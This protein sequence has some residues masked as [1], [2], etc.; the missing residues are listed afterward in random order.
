MLLI[1]VVPLFAAFI[2]WKD[3]SILYQS[4]EMFF[5]LKIGTLVASVA[6]LE[7]TFSKKGEEYAK[8]Y[9]K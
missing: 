1:F 3:T 7:F 4:M 6:A 8:K 2:V 5:I 9:L